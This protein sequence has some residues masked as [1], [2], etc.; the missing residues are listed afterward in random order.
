MVGRNNPICSDIS[1]DKAKMKKKTPR[2]IVQSYNPCLGLQDLKKGYRL[3][4]HRCACENL[5]GPL[6]LGRIKKGKKR[7]DFTHEH[8][9]NDKGIVGH[10]NV[11][12][13]YNHIVHTIYK[14]T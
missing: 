8:H 11:H 6:A 12:V 5:A 4:P 14:L 7:I 2:V 1:Y 13:H 3:K 10:Y 9:Y